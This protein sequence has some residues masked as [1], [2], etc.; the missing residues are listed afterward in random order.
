MMNIS[1]EGR[2]S[3]SFGTS[4]LEI[5]L[6]TP[7]RLRETPEEGPL[8]AGVILGRERITMIEP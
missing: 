5:Y 3:V 2:E 8:V 4:S 7:N 1:L 6:Y